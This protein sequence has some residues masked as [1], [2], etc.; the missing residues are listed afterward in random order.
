MLA[1]ECHDIGYERMRCDLLEED[2]LVR[3]RAYSVHKLR[4]MGSLGDTIKSTPFLIQ[5]KFLVHRD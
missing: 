2:P 4:D 1:L 5:S 3:K